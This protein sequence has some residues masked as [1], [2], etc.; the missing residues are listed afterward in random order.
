MNKL[1]GLLLL[2]LPLLASAQTPRLG[3]LT[4]AAVRALRA[5]AADS[6]PRLTA[7]R[8]AAL[9][10][11]HPG[12]VV[13]QT[14]GTPGLYYFHRQRGWVSIPFDQTPDGSGYAGPGL[15]RA[16]CTVAGGRQPG[17]QE[18]YEGRASFY[19]PYGLVLDGGMLYVA[20]GENH[21]IRQVALGSG[22]VRTVAGCA[23]VRGGYCRGGYQD[24]TG[25]QAEF[26]MPLGVAADGRGHLF[27]ADTHNHRIRRI[28]LATQQVSTLAGSGQ[29]GATDGPAALA[30]FNE[31]H[32][33]AADSAG[34]VY[35]ADTGNNRIRRL[36]AATGQVSTLAGLPYLKYQ[37]Y[38]D[39]AGAQAEFNAPVALVLDRYQGQPVVYV[40]DR[41]NNAV[42]RVALRTGE[43]TT[44]A[45]GPPDAGG[46]LALPYCSGLA[47]DHRGGLYVTGHGGVQ[48]VD[49]ASGTVRPLAGGQQQ[50]ERLP[51]ARPVGPAALVGFG[52][53]VGIAVGATG[54]VYLADYEDSRIAAVLPPDTAAGYRLGRRIARLEPL[55]LAAAG[56]A[57]PPRPDPLALRG[58]VRLLAGAP[59]SH[60]DGTGAA[61]YFSLP[62]HLTRAPDGTLYV[63]DTGNNRI[64]RVTPGGQ[65]S[66][67]A[68]GAVGYADGAAATARFNGPVGVAVAPGGVLYV[69][70][71]GNRRL[72]RIGPDGAVT[73]VAG[74][75]RDPD[76][77]PTPLP[78]FTA[79]APAAQATL[80]QLTDVAVAP[81][82]AV[83]V[84]DGCTVRRLGSDGWLRRL[85]SP[86][87]GYVDGA[88]TTARFGK[89]TA[90]VAAPDGS[91]L[92]ADADNNCLRRLA[93][94]GQVRT[95]AGAPSRLQYKSHDG[96]GAQAYF[97]GLD[98]LALGADG[99]LYAAEGASQR[100]RRITPD[101]RVSTVAGSSEG[102][103]DGPAARARFAY[104]SGVAVAPDG[105]LYVSDCYN[106]RLRT[107]SPA[108]SVRTLAGAGRLS[109]ADGPPALA[110]F[111]YI[112]GLAV[113]P[114]GTLYVAD[115]QNHCIR[116]VAP[117]GTVRTLAGT[118][119]PGYVNGPAA[120]ARFRNP[121][122]V[123]VAPNGTVYVADA[124]NHCVRA[125]SPAGLV[126]TVAGGP[127]AG[128][129]D[130]PAA[131]AR[132]KRPVAVAVGRDGSLYVADAGDGSLRRLR[133][134]GGVST[135]S[136][137][138]VPDD[139]PLAERDLSPELGGLA[140][141][142]G[143]TLFVTN[144]GSHRLYK[145]TPQ[146]QVLLLAGSGRDE[147]WDGPGEAAG[148][149]GP[150]SLA[151]TRTGT[152][153]VA[154]P[155]NGDVRQI[156]PGGYVTT[157]TA[158]PTSRRLPPQVEEVGI[159]AP[160]AVA[161]APDGRLYV[162][163]ATRIWL[164]R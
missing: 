67:V 64:R 72:R 129:R 118:P 151:V 69:A 103:A 5:Q 149:N 59:D 99:T 36:D 146:G 121:A 56:L 74:V 70:D 155:N 123:A 41:D 1:R 39:G 86:M 82:G 88:A 14:D 8:R 131:T 94:D 110:H 44:V 157:L 40:A 33:V 160:S 109:Y 22:R 46:H 81:D 128:H 49:V 9:P 136:Q 30:Q 104:P 54:T 65:V 114:G 156:T 161:T 108:G 120:V 29:R 143:D 12:Q 111:G 90:L 148:L 113:A 163:G 18:G 61:A 134:G 20:E 117:D 107:I 43:V 101:G 63:A 93:P 127:Q 77:Y 37:G 71:A 139:V 116:R 62:T 141:G 140:V 96:L 28:D 52:F 92:V 102:Y 3:T 35:V 58:Q 57:L 112:S 162:A 85:T 11:P 125:I 6:L 152:V 122:G 100:I 51:A 142:R 97:V 38:R 53:P 75:G 13:Y 68:G 87:R 84:T 21:C 79:D 19:R 137:L 16:V 31:P 47:T 24:G 153:Y 145:A 106:H 25:A 158:A 42:R 119:Q 135:V 17:H 48:R 34:N 154:E 78:D 45:G 105:T 10:A 80:N 150:T 15:V 23:S 91:L 133:P 130:G 27:V 95:L 126:R 144:A 7:A 2:L 98:A 132:F 4:P 138:V 124:D 89:L 115:Q 76:T 60:R 83:L 50:P 164:I 147:A 73:T 66:T 159:N 26:N 32:G 55:A